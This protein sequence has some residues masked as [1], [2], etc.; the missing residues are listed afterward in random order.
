MSSNCLILIFEVQSSSVSNVVY[1]FP[2]QLLFG[3]IRNAA[4]CEDHPTASMFL[5][6]YKL[7]SV[8]SVIRLPKRRVQRAGRDDSDD[9]RRVLAIPLPVVQ[10]QT[11]RSQTVAVA[12]ECLDSLS[13]FATDDDLDRDLD[14]DCIP[15]A[16][17]GSAKDNIVYYVA[18]FVVRRCK[19]L[20]SCPTC[21]QNLT[22][23]AN[24]DNCAT[25]LNVKL[26]GALHWPSD[27]LFAALLDVENT[28]ST[29]LS[30]SLTPFMF[31]AIMEESLPAMIALRSVLC[32]SHASTLTAE[33]LVYY[34]S[35]R[36][37]WHA[38]TVNRDV[39]SRKMAKQ[40]RKKTK[41]C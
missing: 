12:A 37:H 27:A 2:L 29:Y 19:K 8:Y 24:T 39:R 32:H 16:P 26:R 5:Q 20:V 3:L 38:K 23:V 41:L 35:T 11:K 10:S 13:A 21:L 15:P 6:L 25:L 31:C 7:L 36:L 30:T 22:S 18:G 9:D 4:G 14:P 34:I 1:G 33:I 40:N 17:T 28:L